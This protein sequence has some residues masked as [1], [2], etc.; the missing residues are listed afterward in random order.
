[1]RFH[2]IYADAQGNLHPEARPAFGSRQENR[3]S[4]FGLDLVDDLGY[5]Y[6]PFAGMEYASLG[7]MEYPQLGYEHPYN[8]FGQAQFRPRLPSRL[9]R[10][11][12][13]A[14]RGAQVVQKTILSATQAQTGAVTQITLT[15]RPQFDFVA[16]DLTF[17]GT[18]A[19]MSINRIR[20]GDRIVF[21]NDGGVPIAVFGT[22]SFVRGLVKGAAISA[23]LDISVVGDTGAGVTGA[24]LVA[25]F[26]G[27]K[28][29]TTGCGPG[30]V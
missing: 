9:P 2:R 12:N 3:M 17:A 22:A 30:A 4:N 10:P 29:G 5:E 1:M 27:L 26:T 19:G 8:N 25:T 21:D 13:A 14:P 11:A 28:R 24:T 15:I 16:E 23:G 18:T 20:F 6:D 7:G